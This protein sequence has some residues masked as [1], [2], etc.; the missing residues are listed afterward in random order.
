VNVNTD[1]KTIDEIFDLFSSDR[2]RHLWRY[3]T[4]S[5]G[6]VFSFEELVDHLTI[7]GENEDRAVETCRTSIEATLHHIDLPRLGDFGLIEYDARSGTVRCGNTEM[8]PFIEDLI[9]MDH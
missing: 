2:R 4:D 9:R 5:D 6:E 3:I 8:R 1:S 7:Q